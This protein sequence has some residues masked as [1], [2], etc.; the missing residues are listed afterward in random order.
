ME[1][2]CW[3]QEPNLERLNDVKCQ[4]FDKTCRR[5]N[6]VRLQRI[7]FGV[8]I[9]LLVKM[10]TL[11]VSYDTW[12]SL[13]EYE[14]SLAPSVFRST[15]LCSKLMYRRKSLTLRFTRKNRNTSQLFHLLFLSVYVFPLPPH[16][17]HG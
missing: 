8:D 6:V 9:F 13:V 3:S 11:I 1:G 17:H 14:V 5:L 15:I 10:Y 12:N 4:A 2:T 7:L 16:F